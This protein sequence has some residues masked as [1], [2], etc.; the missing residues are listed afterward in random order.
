[1]KFQM[2]HLNRIK[3]LILILLYLVFIPNIKAIVNPTKDFYINDYANLLSSETKEYILTKSVALNNADGTQIVV[4]TVPNLEGMDLETYSTKLF[5]NFGIGDSKKNNGLLLLLALEERKFRVEVGYGLEGILPDGKTGRYQ[6]EYIIPY[7]KNNNWDEGIKNGYDAFFAEIVKQNNLSLDYE[8]PVSINDSSVSVFFFPLAFFVGFVL[9]SAIKKFDNSRKKKW[10]SIYLVLWSILLIISFLYIV[11]L[12]F[13][14]IF[15]LMIFLGSLFSRNSLMYY[16][17]GSFGGRGS[18][19]GS[20]GG[21]SGGGGR[22][23]G[24]GSSRGF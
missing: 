12:F 13:A 5:R 14:L 3:L 16:G 7:L 10:T 24:G 23:G 17:G 1:M 18:S 11:D 8:E 20:F 22:S 19:G 21:F 9:G 15:N 2:F 6:D 4:V